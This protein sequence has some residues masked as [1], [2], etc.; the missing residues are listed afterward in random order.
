MS[1]PRWHQRWKPASSGRWPDPVNDLKNRLGLSSQVLAR[2]L[3]DLERDG[4]ID[5]RVYAEVPVR[6]EYS[7]TPLGAARYY[8][9]GCLPY[10]PGLAD[11][12][13]HDLGLHGRERL[14]DVG[15]GPGTIARLLAPLF[16]AVVGL[17][18]DPGML[19]EAARLGA[20]AALPQRPGCKNGLRPCL[21]A[22]DSFGS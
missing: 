12:L 18:P 7:P 17:D 6:V 3:R 2:A 19:A 1:R 9:E 14:L 8:E 22:W 5:R 10:A 21:R 4:L 13:R 16:E 20:E 15:C 11:A